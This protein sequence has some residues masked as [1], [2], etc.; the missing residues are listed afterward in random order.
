MK[1]MSKG[2]VFHNVVLTAT[3]CMDDAFSR[4]THTL[5]WTQMMKTTL[6]LIY[7][8]VDNSGIGRRTRA[9]SV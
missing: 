2:A 6:C 3:A 4:L 8:V 7:A 9:S 1:K 5:M